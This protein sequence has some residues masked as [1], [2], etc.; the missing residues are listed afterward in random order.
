[1]CKLQERSEA[2]IVTPRYLYSVSTVMGISRPV[3]GG[4]GGGCKGVHMHPP[5]DLKYVMY[6]Y[7]EKTLVH[8]GV[9]VTLLS[10][11]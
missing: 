6:S 5:F 8:N 3:V 11:A 10:N 1:M 2:I 4:G 9:T 7:P